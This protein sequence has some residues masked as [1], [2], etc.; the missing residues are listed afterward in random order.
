MLA[1]CL[2]QVRLSQA[3]ASVD[4]KRVIGFGLTLRNRQG[5]GVCKLVIRTHHERFKPV[6]RVHSVIEGISRILIL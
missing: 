5:G 2:H 3:Y 1:D 6:A 4:K